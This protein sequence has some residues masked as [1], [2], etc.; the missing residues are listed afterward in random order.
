MTGPI[1]PIAKDG[2]ESTDKTRPVIDMSV[3]C[4]AHVN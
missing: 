4:K 2:T 3:A 1:N